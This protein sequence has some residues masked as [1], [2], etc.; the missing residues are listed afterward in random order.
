[1]IGYIK[2]VMD[3]HSEG[4]EPKPAGTQ[5]FLLPLW[6]A[7]VRSAEWVKDFKE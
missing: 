1:M 5:L 6:R 7:Y 4:E 3:E 2:Y